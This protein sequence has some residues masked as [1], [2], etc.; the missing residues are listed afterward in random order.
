VPNHRRDFELLDKPLLG[1]KETRKELGVK[2]LTGIIVAENLSKSYRDRKAVDTLTLHIQEGEIFGFLGPNGAGK[3]TTIRLL[4]GI[5][6]PDQGEVVI[7]QCLL[8]QQKKEVA[9][10]IGVMSE[11]P[12]FYDW[13]TAVEYLSFFAHLYGIKEDRLEERIDTILLEVGL[14][15]RK[16][17]T[18]GALSHGMRQR[19]GLARALINNPK[20]LFLDEPT[21]G[22][23]PQGQ[24]DI[25]QL[26]KRLNV[27]GV[28]IFLSSHHLNEISNLCSRIGIIN[29]GKLVAEGTIDDLGKMTSLQ[30]K[31]LTQ[32]FF[33][34]TNEGG[35]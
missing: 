18:I 13:M 2:N 34:L 17:S 5:L 32:I 12:G 25:Q 7:D 4:T 16:H 29:K 21:L 3:T 14:L 6:K 27:E 1:L 26:L 28:T 33:Y 24:E 15:K 10:V 30:D 11:S 9:Q 8:S 19:L 20:I 31:T 23:D 22:L 35:E